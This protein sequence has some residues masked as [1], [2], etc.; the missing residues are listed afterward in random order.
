[1]LEFKENKSILVDGKP[2]TFITFSG[3]EEQ[4]RL[5]LLEGEKNWVE[6][7]AFIK[8]SVDLVHLMLT[9]NALKYEGIEIC[10]STLKLP[11]LPYA[12]Q[13]RVCAGAE[14]FSL[15]VFAEVINSMGFKTVITF[16]VHSKVAEELINNLV[17]VLPHEL[18]VVEKDWFDRIVCPDEGAVQRT[19]GFCR[20]AGDI[21]MVH[22]GKK[23]DPKTGH[24]IE[25]VLYNTDVD[26]KKCLI[27][28]D[29]CD[30]GRTFI[31]LA[32]VLKHYGATKVSLYVTHGIF[33]KGLEPLEGFIDEVFFTNSL[34]QDPSLK[35]SSS[36]LQ[37][38]V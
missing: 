15:E 7:E 1:M 3:G 17:N 26:G 23:R 25:T 21:P 30:G 32:K 11:Y 2:I 13:D 5:P 22:A 6:I 31:E 4:I 9:V 27:V 16:D 12:R 10:N 8:S 24:I 20:A 34:N 28:D 18:F 29:I 37:I 38:K 35:G 19:E 14:A 36:I 33:S